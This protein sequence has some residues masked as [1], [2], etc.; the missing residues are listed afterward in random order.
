MKYLFRTEQLTT[1]QTITKY[2]IKTIAY[3]AITICKNYL[4]KI[5]IEI[6]TLLILDKYIVCIKRNQ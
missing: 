4:L 6:I 2:S 1:H 3:L 5:I